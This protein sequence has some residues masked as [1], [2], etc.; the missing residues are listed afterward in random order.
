MI[1]GLFWILLCLSG[2]NDIIPV[3]NLE[4]LYSL[5]SIS[6]S[7]DFTQDLQIKSL[8]FSSPQKYLEKTWLDKLFQGE[9]PDELLFWNYFYGSDDPRVRATSK[10]MVEITTKMLHI[11]YRYSSEFQLEVS[12]T[13]NELIIAE[14]NKREPYAKYHLKIVPFVGKE[15]DDFLQY[16]HDHGVDCLK[17]Q[18]PESWIKRKDWK[19]MSVYSLDNV[20]PIKKQSRYGE[21]WQNLNKLYQKNHLLYYGLGTY[22]EWADQ[23]TFYGT[24]V[25]YRLWDPYFFYLRNDFY[26]PSNWSRLGLLSDWIIDLK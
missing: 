4:S 14:Y 23:C 7:S 12:G 16:V 3:Q 2:N 15:G 8:W 9:D 10:K 11:L 19:L 24:L 6:K 17:L 1:Q 25:F 18:S 20:V 22:T 26:S 13:W 21:F 5:T